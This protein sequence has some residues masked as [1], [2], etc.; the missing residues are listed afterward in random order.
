MVCRLI[1]TKTLSNIKTNDELRFRDIPAPDNIS[2]GCCCRNSLLTVINPLNW[3]RSSMDVPAPD[4]KLQGCCCRNSRPSVTNLDY[5][6]TN[7][8]YIYRIYDKIRSKSP[9]NRATLPTCLHFDVTHHPLT[10]GIAAL[11]IPSGRTEC[12]RN[13][14]RHVKLCG[15]LM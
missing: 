2:L 5:N 9:P 6:R 15:Q 3:E 4:N 10:T 14:V 7:Q 1:D 11:H 12:V 8:L 13:V